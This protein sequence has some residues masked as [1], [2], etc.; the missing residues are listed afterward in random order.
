MI[1]ALD[2][3]Q[4]RRLDIYLLSSQERWPCRY[5]CPLTGRWYHVLPSRVPVANI[6]ANIPAH[7]ERTYSNDEKRRVGTQNVSKGQQDSSPSE[8][9]ALTL[10]RARKQLARWSRSQGKG[11]QRRLSIHS[12]YTN[13]KKLGYMKRELSAE[14]VLG[15]Y[16]ERAPPK[17]TSNLYV[18]SRKRGEKRMH[19]HTPSHALTLLSHTR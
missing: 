11:R 12:Q 19:T 4:I 18:P 9:V 10:L 13:G 8:S 15:K 14:R 6:P 16:T 2:P 1:S 7:T 17:S 3:R 5:V